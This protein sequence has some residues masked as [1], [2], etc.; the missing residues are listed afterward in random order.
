MSVLKKVEPQSVSSF[1]IEEVV[2]MLIVRSR[3]FLGSSR[4]LALI[5][6]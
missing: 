3:E 5:G 4:L 6:W 1:A 2:D